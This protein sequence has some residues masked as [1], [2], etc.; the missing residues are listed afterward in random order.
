MG[1]LKTIIHNLQRGKSIEYNLNQYIGEMMTNGNRLSFVRAALN[2][3]LFYEEISQ[4]EQS[5]QCPECI[6]QLSYEL[7]HLFGEAMRLEYEEADVPPI[8]EKAFALRERI[9]AVMQALTA[10]GDRYTIYEYVLNRKEYSYQDTSAMENFDDEAFR[11]KIMAYISEAPDQSGNRMKL[12]QILEQ[13][14]MR[15]TRSRFA[16]IIEDGL[17]AYIGSEKSSV[18]DLLYMIR[19]GAL[20]EE[21][22]EM[23]SFFP[24]LYEKS[25]YVKDRYNQTMTKEQFQELL[26]YFSGFF[27]TLNEEMDSVLL[28]QELINDL[29]S[30]LL[31]APYARANETERD[32]CVQIIREINRMFADPERSEPKDALDE[33]FVFL[34]GRQEELF[35][36]KERGDAVLEEFA[37]AYSRRISPQQKDGFA[38]LRKISLLL[39]TSHFG[40]LNDAGTVT[41]EAEEAYIMQKAGELIAQL[42]AQFKTMSKP[43]VRAVM[44]KTLT[45]LPLFVRNYSEL[46]SY[47][48]SSLANCTDLA[49]KMAC[50]EIIH[51][52]LNDEYWEDD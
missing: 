48:D 15:M 35:E 19:T 18:E 38:A 40:D 45:M 21:P 41:E 52:M 42:K 13:I 23:A 14:P 3:P 39:S 22:E 27:Q 29:C 51:Q 5:G 20:L 26:Q 47:L 2:Y 6:R 11:N 50:V 25:R 9:T 32:C 1:N 31:S 49:E 43:E 17:R 7:S 12:V 36:Q 33:L 10:F 24:D 16:Q 44:A 34:E 8:L 4:I 46:Q 37:G 30:I 28:M